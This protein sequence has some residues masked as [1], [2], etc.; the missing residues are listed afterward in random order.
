MYVEAMVPMP[1]G[2]DT[3]AF[4]KALRNAADV[5]AVA[6]RTDCLGSRRYEAFTSLSDW[7]DHVKQS[8][9]SIEAVR[10]LLDKYKIP[11]GIENH[12]DW[13]A[14]A[15]VDLMKQYGTEY[16]GACLDFGNNISLLDDPVDVIE[17]LAPYTVSTHLK[18]MAVAS[19]EDGFLLSEVLLGS[20]YLDLSRAISVV[21]SARPKT[22]FSL[23]MISRDPLKVPCL[24]DK[25]WTTFPDRNGLYLARTLRFVQQHQNKEPLP[26]VKQLSHEEQLRNEEANVVACLKYANEKLSL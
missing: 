12:K 15:L 22:R 19:Y 3:A 5:G 24:T 26:Q 2:A 9:Q 18:D 4:E 11:L 1:K 6:L 20:G 23:E 10:P 25:Y 21:R 16:L 17:K 7:Q 14:D 13:T 8:R